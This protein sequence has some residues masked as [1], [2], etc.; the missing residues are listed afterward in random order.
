M[1][2]S[3][4][5]HAAIRNLIGLMVNDCLHES[6][7][8]LRDVEPKS[9]DDIRMLQ[10]SIISFSEDVYKIDR[11]LK[12]FLL[13]K[14]YRHE[15]VRQM[16]NKADKIVRELFKLLLNNPEYLPSDWREKV[17]STNKKNTPTVVAD[18]IAGMT[19]RFAY[20]E[21]NKLVRK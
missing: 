16:T 9:P 13:E 14:M 5:R 15:R 18:Y 12:D 6:E 4:Q 19:D 10:H 17:T 21:H 1:S 2:K 20:D 8:R 7:R 3:L 11:I